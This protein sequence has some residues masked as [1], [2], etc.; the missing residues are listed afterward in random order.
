MSWMSQL[1]DTYENNI[2][3][4]KKSGVVMTPIAHMNVNAHL[5]I[6]IDMDGNFIA[7][8]KVDKEDANTLIPVTESSAGR[9]SGKAPHILSDTLSYIAGD[10]GDYC[11]KEK[12]KKNAEEKFEKYIEQLK[13]WTFSD[14]TNPK[15]QAI[16]KYLSK[17]ILVSDMVKAGIITQKDDK[18][19]DDKK[20]SGQAYEKVMV[21]FRVLDGDK[22]LTDCTWNDTALIR[23]YTDYFLSEQNGQKDICYLTGRIGVRTDNHPKGIVDANY[24]AKLISANDN[25]GYTYRGRF[26]N[27][28]QAYSLSYE[29]S[30]K[31]HSAL[32]WLVKNQGAYVG[33]KVKRFFVCWNPK[34]KELP[35]IFEEFNLVDDNNSN[36]DSSYKK[37]LY[38][39]LLGYSNQ[40]S[41][42]DFVNVIGLEAATTGRL[43]ITYYNEMFASDFFDRIRVSGGTLREAQNAH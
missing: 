4:E 30:Q 26:L 2:G 39:S 16:Y 41:E 24:G 3:I 12:D 13:K 6:T 23:A 28:D 37:K 7:V 34:G 31:I 14:Y 20:I 43:S 10:F 36:N 40:F 27:A 33:T 9:S 38:K 18:F 42:E 17:R 22:S 5:E 11:E 35:D 1:Y 19:L 32:T 25:Q 15:V 29:A 21:R 8:S